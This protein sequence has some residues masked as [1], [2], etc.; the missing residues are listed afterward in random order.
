MIALERLRHLEWNRYPELNSEKLSET[1]AAYESWPSSGTVVATG[2]NALISLLIQLSALNGRVITVKPNFSLYSLDANLLGASLTEIPLGSDMSINIDS[3]ID[4]LGSNIG[5]SPH[6]VI[7]IPRPHAP[8]GTLLDLE[9]LDHLAR[10]C[11]GWLLVVDEAYSHFSSDDARCIARK[12]E[13]VVLLRTFSKAWGLAGMRLGYALTSDTV[14]RQ[15]RKLVPPFTV[16]LMQT[17]CAQVALEYPSYV[18]ERVAVTISERERVVSAL[19]GHPTWKVFPSHA[20]FLLIQTPDAALAHAK[21][22]Q[23]GILVRRQDSLHGLQGCIRVTIGTKEQ[24]DAFL[25]ASHLCY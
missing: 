14:A 5:S 25:L 7:F 13:H 21:L 18:K 23:S 3:L 20:N 24:N 8:C 1:I 19:K 17:V 4:A 2:S 22:L 6:G 9:Y 10:S 12:H 11:P 16:S 15:L